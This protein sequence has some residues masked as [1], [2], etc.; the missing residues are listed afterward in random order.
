MSGSHNVRVD[1]FVRW[2]LKGVH[3]HGKLEASGSKGGVQCTVVDWRPAKLEC[4]MRASGLLTARGLQVSALANLQKT[5]GWVL[6]TNVV[7][8]I[9]QKISRF[10]EKSFNT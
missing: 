10:T 7:N 4:I 2:E 6:V 5:T 3:S 8:L 9:T 1:V